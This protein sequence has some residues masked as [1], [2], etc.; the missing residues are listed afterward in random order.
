MQMS[1]QVAFCPRNLLVVRFVLILFLCPH[2]RACQPSDIFPFAHLIGIYITDLF[3]FF[4]FSFFLARRN[5]PCRTSHTPN[6][7][8][9]NVT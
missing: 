2:S 8:L 4:F 3:F 9:H 7:T 6:A 1:W 5:Q